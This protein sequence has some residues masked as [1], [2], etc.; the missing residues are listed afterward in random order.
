MSQITTHVLD[1]SKGKPAEGIHINLQKKLENDQWEDLA[2]GTTNN[3]GRIPD[4]LPDHVEI[5][6]GIYRM[7]FDTKSYFEKYKS[8]AFYPEVSVVFEL[9]DSAHFRVYE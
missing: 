6:P 3:D 9:K 8:E 4:F 1:T 7:H 2:R 5:T